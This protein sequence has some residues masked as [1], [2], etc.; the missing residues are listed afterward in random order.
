MEKVIEFVIRLCGISAVI[1]VFAIFGFVFW[2]GK[3]LLLGG[4][5]DFWKFLTTKE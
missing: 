1:F 3:G 4:E 5:F 2:E